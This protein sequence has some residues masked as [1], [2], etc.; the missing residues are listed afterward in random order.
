[1]ATVRLRGIIKDFGDVRA[2]DDIS[3]DVQEGEFFSLLGP[4]G[5]GK[6]T[7]LRMLAGFEKP[8][9][10][11]IFFNAKDVTAIRP[12]ERNVG[13]VFQNYALFAHL[14][15]GENIAFGLKARKIE[16]SE[17]PARVKKALHLVDLTGLAD[18]AVSALSGGQQQRVAL[19]RALVIEPQILLLDE[20]LSNLDAKLRVET[21]QR[22]QELQ[23]KLGI[24]TFYVTHDQQE[25]LTQSDRI[26]VFFAGKCVQIGAPRQIFSKPQSRTVMDFL[27][28]ANF[29]S[30][31]IIRCGL[32]VLPGGIELKIPQDDLP[33]GKKITIG[34]RPHEVEL[35]ADKPT[36]TAEVCG[37]T[38]LGEAEEIVLRAGE[39]EIETLQP[40]TGD[41]ASIS[42]GDK[43]PIKLPFEN[44]NIFE[45]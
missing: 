38:F 19:A 5:C 8:T 42:T 16:K 12:Q 27:G 25:A 6:T 40:H 20:P 34:F 22:I 24:T 21:R 33:A 35:F 17:I 31:E 29:I 28:R 18:R 37:I 7:T 44:L 14:S 1:M 2:V 15:V 13:M 11:S 30:A 43:I 26:A 36:L 39:I 9:A 32:A 45:E 10:G 23:Q 41:R 3:L 4:S